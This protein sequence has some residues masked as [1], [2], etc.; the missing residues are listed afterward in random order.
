MS[1]DVFEKIESVVEQIHDTS[2]AVEDYQRNHL[3]APQHLVTLSLALQEELKELQK[4][5]MSVWEDGARA[6][7]NLWKSVIDMAFRD[8]WSRPLTKIV[9]ELE[10]TN[11]EIERLG[12]LHAKVGKN[13]KARIRSQIRKNKKKINK[14]MNSNF[15]TAFD[16]L[17]GVENQARL[18]R[19]GIDPET[20][21]ETIH[22]QMIAAPTIRWRNARLNYNNYLTLKRM[23]ESA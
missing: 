9:D 5:R 6:E 13:E 16:F 11:N 8:I 10:R 17:I 21:R 2:Q 18:E 19:L 4:I 22:R 14:I 23:E 1:V 20:L 7:I 15:M 12:F 3:D